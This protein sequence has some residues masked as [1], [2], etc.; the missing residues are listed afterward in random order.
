MT[1]HRVGERTLTPVHDLILEE[2]PH[3]GERGNLCVQQFCELLECTFGRSTLGRGGPKGHEQLVLL[4]ISKELDLFTEALEAG[5]S[6]DTR[7]RCQRFFEQRSGNRA[8][9]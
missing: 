5:L 8:V 9:I 4:T 1:R 2:Q 6:D 3:T 7:D